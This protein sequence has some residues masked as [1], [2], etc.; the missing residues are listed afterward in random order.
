ME[1]QG[2]PTKT[3]K[4]V[5]ADIK[6]CANRV[7]DL[8]GNGHTESVYRNALLYELQSIPNLQCASEVVVP[9]PYKDVIVGHGRIDILGVYESHKIVIELKALSINKIQLARFISQVKKYMI[10]LNPPADN[11]LLF[12]FSPDL[13]RPLDVISLEKNIA[14]T[15]TTTEE[16]DP[17]HGTNEQVTFEEY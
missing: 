1:Q 2:D 3:V 17:N 5:L 7:Y 15:P 4:Q 13:F 11:A 14:E 16:P 12:N 9:I 6:N 8:L 10:Y